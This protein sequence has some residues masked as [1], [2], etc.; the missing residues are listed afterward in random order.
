MSC[1]KL[2]AGFGFSVCCLTGTNFTIFLIVSSGKK[3]VS[4]LKNIHLLWGH[5]QKNNVK[6]LEVENAWVHFLLKPTSVVTNTQANEKRCSCHMKTS[7]SWPQSYLRKYMKFSKQSHY[8]ILFNILVNIICHSCCQK[9]QE[10]V[11]KLKCLQI[12]R[13]YLIY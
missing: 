12:H 6:L 1:Y 11:G 7:P 10:K 13:F 8:D 4:Y 9:L 2:S 3:T 5:F